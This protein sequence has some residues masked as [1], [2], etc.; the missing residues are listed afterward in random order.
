MV[1][2]RSEGRWGSEAWEE[3]KECAVG[4]AKKRV[5][6]R[7]RA[8]KMKE[9]AGQ[10]SPEAVCHRLHGGVWRGMNE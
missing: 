6:G 2:G 8:G 10:E 5:K 9:W 3:G 7:G 4:S 1:R